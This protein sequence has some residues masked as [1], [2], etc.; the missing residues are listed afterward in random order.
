MF[1]NTKLE[2]LNLPYNPFKACIVPRPIGWITTQNI[3]NTTNVAPFSY[4][5][6]VS[7]IPPIVM[8]SCAKKTVGGN[9]DTSVNIE[10]SGEFV[11]NIATFDQSNAMNN[12]SQE[13]D[14][15]VSEAN[16]FSIKTIPSIMVHPP[17]IK[18][19]PIRLECKFIKTTDLNFDDHFSNCQVIFGHVVGIY[20]D[21]LI[22]TAGK[23]D[24]SKFKPIARLGYDEYAVID[25]VFKMKRS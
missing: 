16:I 12:S 3:N 19:S 18:N 10:R 20:I 13:L 5:N 8:F 14:Y 23:V 11:V 1:I 17:G 21:D 7:D 9:K 22:I 2:N 4:F 6:A 24:I 25:R 15:G